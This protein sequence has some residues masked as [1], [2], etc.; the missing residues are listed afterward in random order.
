MDMKTLL[1][2]TALGLA[3]GTAP[4]FAD[5]TAEDVWH[6]FKAQMSIYDDSFRAT[7]EKSGD[8]LTVRLKASWARLSFGSLVTAPCPWFSRIS[9]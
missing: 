3:V 7:E 2:T 9:T 4:G 1:G 6:E 8:T 5:V